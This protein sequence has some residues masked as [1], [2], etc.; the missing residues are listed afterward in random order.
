MKKT[1]KTALV[2][3]FDQ[4]GD[5]T[6][7]VELTN[8]IFRCAYRSGA[9]EYLIDAKSDDG[10]VYSG[11]WSYEGTPCG[12]VTLTRFQNSKLNQTVLLGT[13][14]RDSDANRGTYCVKLF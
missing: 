6:P 12:T 5:K 4:N 10:N 7:K 14:T 13:W 11:N 9:D 8:E 1:T 2:F 3:D